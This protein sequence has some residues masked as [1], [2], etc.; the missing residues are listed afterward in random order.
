M[1]PDHGTGYRQEHQ[2]T[3]RTFEK[4]VNIEGLRTS[5]VRWLVKEQDS[6]GTLLGGLLEGNRF[7][8]GLLTFTGLSKKNSER[9]KCATAVFAYVHASV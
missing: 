3:E 5:V 9:R 4:L 1:D 2:L 6:W 8:T 7:C